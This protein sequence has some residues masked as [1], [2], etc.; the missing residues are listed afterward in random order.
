MSNK[1]INCQL[2]A[3]R[4]FISNNQYLYNHLIALGVAKLGG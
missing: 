4:F 3:S 2:L 1:D